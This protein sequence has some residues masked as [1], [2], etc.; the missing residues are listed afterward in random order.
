MLRWRIALGTLMILF[1]G[2]LF[3]FDWWFYLESGPILRRIPP[4]RLLTSGLIIG[5]F[6]SILAAGGAY[7]LIRLARPTGYDPPVAITIITAGLLPLLPV[8]AR[9]FTSSIDWWCWTAWMMGLS[10]L[11]SFMGQLTRKEITGAVISTA[12]GC[13]AVLYI[14]L[15]AAF[16]A[17]LRADFG[18]AGFVFLLVV[19]KSGDIGAYFTGLRFGRT[20]LI[21]WL[22]PGKTVEGL[23]G[24]MVVAG[25]L[26]I[27][28]TRLVYII[29][30]KGQLAEL[31]IIEAFTIGVIL[32]AIGHF[33]DLVESLI[34][35]DCSAKDSSKLLPAFGGILDLIDSV[36]PAA[37]V[38]YAA[39]SLSR[40]W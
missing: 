3:A 27:G 22:S 13:L 21:P 10:V 6:C 34:K 18:P 36:L 38:W 2:A 33:G 37:L 15:P 32:A 25:L 23:V 11:V 14:G 5:L 9:R 4:A 8:L 29:D 24:A 16:A 7:E 28:F 40:F 17:A 35:R 31:R 26:A 19:V 12:L 1:I 39:L 30:G 20:K